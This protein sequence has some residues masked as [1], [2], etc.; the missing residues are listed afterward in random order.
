MSRSLRHR[1]NSRTNPCSPHDRESLTTTFARTP[2]VRVPG[3]TKR[4]HTTRYRL[5]TAATARHQHLQTRPALAAPPRNANYSGAY[6]PPPLSTTNASAQPSRATLL[7]R[8][9][10]KSKNALRHAN[11]DTRHSSQHA[12]AYESLKSREQHAHQPDSKY[13]DRRPG[14]TT[15][16]PQPHSKAAADKRRICYVFLYLRLETPLFQHVSITQSANLTSALPF[17]QRAT[18]P[19]LYRFRTD[20]ICSGTSPIHRRPHY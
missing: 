1:G 12:I 19:L 16:N 9:L 10:P 20:P 4:A 11:L 18:R 2:H 14:R 3:P 5:K 8:S 6:G 7:T 15:S 13:R 17:A